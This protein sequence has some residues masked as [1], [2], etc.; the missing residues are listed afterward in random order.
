VAEVGVAIGGALALAHEAG[1][2]HRDVKPA[3]ILVDRHGIPKLADFGIARDDAQE[4]ALTREGV[5]IGTWAFMPPEQREGGGEVDARSDIY[6]FGVTLY[7]L[8]T[9]RR[10]ASLHNQ[11][12][13]T[14]LFKDIDPTLATIL[15]RAVRLYPEDRY[16]RIT[17]MVEDL[18]RYLAGAQVVAVA[19]SH[20]EPKTWVPVD[21]AVPEPET[22]PRPST[23]GARMGVAA[24]I[25][26]AVVIGGGV[27]WRILSPPA[28]T[29]VVAAAPVLVEPPPAEAPPVTAP[30]VELPPA[31]VPEPKAPV[32]KAPPTTPVE[33]AAPKVITVLSDPGGSTG[34]TTPTPEGVGLA[35]ATGTVILRTVP[36]GATVKLKGR[37]LTP[38]SG[39][40]YALP[41]GGHTLDVT[42]ATG[43]QT[44]VA[45]S[46]KA[47]QTVEICYDFDTNSA[48][49]SKR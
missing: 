38:G 14:D 28:E 2:V 36:S 26:V 3:N 30:P 24:G 18:K 41:V 34:A 11:E 7:A 21:T 27:T 39:G 8:L 20:P 29:P 1:L 37:A 31:P 49:G 47:G 4:K 9:G 22:P 33:K 19:P 5:V 6:A 43:E 13:W 35:A 46:V 25:L 44:R 42:S 32:V 12:G 45:V 17:E 23:V 10:E 48:C 16:P 40:G 15:Q